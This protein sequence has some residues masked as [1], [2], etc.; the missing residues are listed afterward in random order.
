MCFMCAMRQRRKVSREKKT[1]DPKK[2]AVRGKG[3]GGNLDLFLFARLGKARAPRRWYEVHEIPQRLQP[4]GRCRRAVTKKKL[5]REGE[6][7]G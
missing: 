2:K 7:K 3:R 1:S 6:E 5:K 4:V